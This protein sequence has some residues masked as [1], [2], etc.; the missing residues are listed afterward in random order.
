MYGPTS[1]LTVHLLSRCYMSATRE[2]LTI[3]TLAVRRLQRLT[4]A[5]LIA[6]TKLSSSSSSSSEASWWL[7][8]HT[9]ELIVSESCGDQSMDISNI[10]TYLERKKSVVKKCSD[11]TGNIA[12]GPVGRNLC[13]A[14]MFSVGCQHKYSINIY[15]ILRNTGEVHYREMM[16]KLTNEWGT[17][18]LTATH[19]W[20]VQ[21]CHHSRLV[22]IPLH[23][24]YSQAFSHHRVGPICTNLKKLREKKIKTLEEVCDRGKRTILYG[25][26]CVCENPA[27]QQLGLKSVPIGQLDLHP[28]DGICLMGHWP[29]VLHH[30][31]PVLDFYAS[32]KQ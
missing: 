16:W 20:Q 7:V 14:T 24:G 5:E 15:Y 31:W 21:H 18:S 29:D 17:D 1:Q 23:C 27:D 8:D 11:L 4:K 3:N 32:W 2:N 12:I 9:S 25:C 13:Q 6:S 10:Y 30:F 22:I 19:L 28:W 26:L